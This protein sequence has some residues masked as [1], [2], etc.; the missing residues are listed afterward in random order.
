MKN[1]FKKLVC[2]QGL[3]YVGSAMCA[4]VAS[5][6]DNAGNNY[7][8]VVGVDLNT[9][10]GRDRVKKINQGV[11]PFRSS[12]KLLE[13]TLKNCHTQKNLNATTDVNIFK[14]AD[15]IIV[16][17]QLDITSLKGVPLA[18]MEVLR[19]AINTLS[20]KIKKGVLIIIE[21]TVP[22]GTCEN[23]IKPI[24]EKGIIKRGFNKDD[25]ML[26][27]SY[28]RVMP[29]PNYLMSIKNYWRVFSGMNNKSE[30]SCEN[31][32]EKIIN[33]EEFPLRKMSSMR[34]SETAKIVENSFRAVNI[35]FM[36][37]WGRFA[38]GIGV[39][40][41]EIIKAVRDRPSHKNIRKPGLGVGG[42]C[43]TKDPYFAEIS[44]NLY[45]NELDLDFPIIKKAVDINNKMPF[46]NWKRIENFFGKLNT[47]KI[48]LLGVAYKADVDD[49]RYSPSNILYQ[50]LKLAGAKIIVHD[51]YVK[52]WSEIGIKVENK[53]PSTKDIDGIIIAVSH[54]F[55]KNSYF[56]EWLNSDILKIYDC[57]N[58]FNQSKIS[59]LIKKGSKI[60]I[61]GKG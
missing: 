9:K 52:I 17:V 1:N 5:A 13:K 11:F 38:E 32:L 30:K 20:S 58:T 36:D 46:R 22:P 57:V 24:L 10:K 25:F 41:F 61:T 19:E 44:K 15:I 37:E 26:A 45:Y 50:K 33:H 54:T 7:F 27:H 18:S 55:Y 34:A 43:L 53:L 39:D 31:F 47:K 3:G 8:D 29:G 28:E 14:E 42:Y 23:F 56:F 60:L 40:M 4:C 2:I 51:P 48:L 6:N 21:T 49:T 12:D 16:D 35:A 59:K